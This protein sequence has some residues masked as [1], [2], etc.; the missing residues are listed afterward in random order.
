MK[1]YIAV[2]RAK[3]VENRPITTNKQVSKE[4]IKEIV[5]NKD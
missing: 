3:R 2:L 4:H 1:N 5:N